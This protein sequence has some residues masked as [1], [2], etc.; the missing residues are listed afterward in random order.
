M[1]SLS[2][3][4]LIV[5][6]QTIE[7]SSFS[8]KDAEKV[9]TAKRELAMML[10]EIDSLESQAKTEGMQVAKSGAEIDPTIRKAGARSKN[11]KKA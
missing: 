8:G 4:T 2:R 3:Q 1:A 5:A 11:D 7:A 9:M 10:K 6:F